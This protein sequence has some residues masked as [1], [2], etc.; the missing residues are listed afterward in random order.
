[1]GSNNGGNDE[2][3]V[4]TVYLDAFYIDKYEMTQAQ[5]NKFLEA[6]P[7]WGSPSTDN[8]YD[9]YPVTPVSWYA[10][11]AYAK[12]AGKRLPTESE[13]EKAA[14]GGLVGQAYPWGNSIDSS[15]VFLNG[16]MGNTV[17]V[18]SY[19]P[20]NYGLYDMAGN[21]WEWCLDQYDR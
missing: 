21:A 11:M 14:R 20:N 8:T 18:G 6:N 3:P 13:W 7:Q 5:Y 12:W 19:P 2:K 15:K 17:P 16:G 1:M 4:H 10:A 9:N